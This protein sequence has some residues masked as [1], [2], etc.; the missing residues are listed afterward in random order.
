MNKNINKSLILSLALLFSASFK[1]ITA[2]NRLGNLFGRNNQNVT[3]DVE[4]NDV[5]LNGNN[6]DN[7]VDIEDLQNQL[8][9]LPAD[10]LDEFRIDVEEEVV[11][12][13]EIPSVRNRDFLDDIIDLGSDSESD[14]EEDLP[15]IKDVESLPIPEISSVRNRD[16]LDDIIDLGSD[17]EDDSEEQKD[18]NINSEAES[19]LEV[20]QAPVESLT[21]QPIEIVVMPEPDV[22]SSELDESV[23]VAKPVTKPSKPQPCEL[24]VSAPKAKVKSASISQP[25]ACN[26]PTC[27]V[28]KVAK[29]ECKQKTKSLEKCKKAIKSNKKTCK[30]TKKS[31]TSLKKLKKALAKKLKN[32][33]TGIQKIKNC[34]SKNKNNKKALLKFKKAL[35]KKYKQNKNNCKQ[36][37]SVSKQL[38]SIKS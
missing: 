17:S 1:P 37:K 33:K 18:A 38:R 14:N 19:N 3:N 31:I 8:A 21:P 35:C 5:E 16:F 28:N 13:S 4:L 2:G 23:V 9:D 30:K 12:A 10:A 15:E 36:L 34:I 6:E 22:N 32:N 7:D 20:N 24:P 26:L 25:K 11:P 29:S 27:N